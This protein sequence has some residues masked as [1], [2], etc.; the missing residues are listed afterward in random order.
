MTLE[1][2]STI[3]FYS[4]GMTGEYFQKKD[5]PHMYLFAKSYLSDLFIDSLVETKEISF[6]RLI[7]Y[8]IILVNLLYVFL[9]YI[10]G[11]T[12]AKLMN[13]GE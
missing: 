13:Y 5:K 11:M 2:L 1:E 7:I 12:E 9:S 4:S 8:A 3:L 10:L 6:I